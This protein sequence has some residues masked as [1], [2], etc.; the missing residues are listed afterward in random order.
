MCT[1]AAWACVLPCAGLTATS[2]ASS[3]A[4]AK[5]KAA[6]YDAIYGLLKG[7]QICYFE[8]EKLGLFGAAVAEAVAKAFAYARADVY[9]A[10]GTYGESGMAWRGLAWHGFAPTAAACMRA[11]QAGA[12][13]AHGFLPQKGGGACILAPAHAPAPA[14]AAPADYTTGTAYAA[15][16]SQAIAS[17]C[18]EGYLDAY[19]QV[20]TYCKALATEFSVSAIADAFVKADAY[21]AVEVKASGGYSVA[22]SSVYNEAFVKSATY[23]AVDLLTFVKANCDC[24][25]YYSA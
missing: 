3:T 10:V 11:A 16:A 23:V 17:A 25:T 15:S 13:P 12:L 21:A 5:A 22:G 18:A 8:P 14:P 19:K 7:N 4:A 20:Y 24:I 1:D 6:V 2:S 9:A